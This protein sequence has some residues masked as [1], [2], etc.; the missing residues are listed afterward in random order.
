MC[1]AG[2][3]IRKLQSQPTHSAV[4]VTRKEKHLGMPNANPKVAPA[5]ASPSPNEHFAGLTLNMVLRILVRFISM[6]PE[7]TPVTP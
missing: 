5:P 1:D 2:V 3:V 7:L 6:T 4:T